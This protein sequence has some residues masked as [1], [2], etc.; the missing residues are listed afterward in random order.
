MARKKADKPR[1][2]LIVPPSKGGK[3]IASAYAIAA[4]ILASGLV[5][6]SAWLA[7]SSILSPK[8]LAFPNPFLPSQNQASTGVAG[9]Q[10]L[11]EIEAEIK[12][13]EQIP[14]TPIPLE[15]KKTAVPLLFPVLASIS[16]CQQQ[17]QQIVELRVYR[18]TDEEN[19]YELVDR[20]AIEGLEEVFV[21]DTLKAGISDYKASARPLPL[22][23]IAQFDTKAPGVWFNLSGSREFANTSV[24]YGQVVRY[25]PNSSYLSVKLSWT[26]P[27]G[28][29]AYWQEVTSDTNPDLIVNQTVGIEPR[30]RIYQ[31]KSRQ[32][33]AD[34]VELKEILLQP[35]ALKDSAYQKALI[36]ADKGLWTTGWEMLSA[37]KLKS[38]PVSAQAQMGLMKLH[39][40]FA[41][42]QLNQ[43]WASPSQ[44]VLVN[45][46][47]GRWQEALKVFE[48]SEFD[49]REI[50][51]SLKNDADRLWQ[52]VE[53]ALQVKSDRDAIAWGAILI[54]VREG[55]Q[56][57]LDWLQSQPQTTTE[58]TARIK[59]L[60]DQLQQAIDRGNS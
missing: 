41:R 30:F 39:A 59:I 12:Q 23:Q 11:G 32:F 22:T 40:E 44:E 26:S 10:T 48:S 17:C 49:R 15:P 28:Q 37:L 1:V 58:S 52:R 20:V 50:A 25:D 42:S 8:P 35:P 43:T 34:P 31:L 3:W 60:L 19:Y 24:L 21:V 54:A 53:V 2:H 6:G 33:A 46:M 16:P 7:V 55:K 36:L 38:L 14:G 47:N 18:P 9:S 56:E 45:L 51:M 57:A 29:A 5:A 27:A 4:L 13:K